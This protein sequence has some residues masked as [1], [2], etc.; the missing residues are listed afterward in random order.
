MEYRTAEEK[1]LHDYAAL[2]EEN[3]RLDDENLRLKERVS[4][5]E[6][7]LDDVFEQADKNKRMA[8][9]ALSCIYDMLL[10]AIKH[11]FHLPIVEAEE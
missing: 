11:D 5:L 8:D 10:S 6:K 1:L 2:E 7:R 9:R 3:A 4:E